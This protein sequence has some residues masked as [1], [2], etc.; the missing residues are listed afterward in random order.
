MSR[1]IKTI[2]L[3]H[4]VAVTSSDGDTKIINITDNTLWYLRSTDR[5]GMMNVCFFE[6]ADICC[7][8]ESNNMINV[9]NLVS[10]TSKRIRF[11]YYSGTTDIIIALKYPYLLVSTSSD[12]YL[13]NVDSSDHSFKH[14]SV[15]DILSMVYIRKYDWLV[16]STEDRLIIYKLEYQESGI[17]W[18]EIYT[19]DLSPVCNKVKFIVPETFGVRINNSHTEIIFSSYHQ[20]IAVHPNG[21]YGSFKYYGHDKLAIYTDDIEVYADGKSLVLEPETKHQMEGDITCIAYR[22]PKESEINFLY[23]VISAAFDDYLPSVSIDIVCQFIC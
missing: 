19:G 8:S 15:R 18:D 22:E 7:I 16:V 1:L 2:D 10:C 14:F 17:S 23:S 11:S 21:Y 3:P 13:V 6:D 20:E 5:K 4:L 12:A 9:Y